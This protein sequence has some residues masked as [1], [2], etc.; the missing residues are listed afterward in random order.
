MT[1]MIIFYHFYQRKINN[2]VKIN[3]PLIPKNVKVGKV[4]VFIVNQRIALIY[5]NPNNLIFMVIKRN[6]NRLFLYVKLKSIIIKLF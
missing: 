4:L 5:K 2:K 6:N 3:F 1:K